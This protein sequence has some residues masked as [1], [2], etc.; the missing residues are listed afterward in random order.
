[1]TIIVVEEKKILV[2]EKNRREG[3]GVKWV[4]DRSDEAKKFNK[5]PLPVA[6]AR[7][8]KVYF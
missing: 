4:R 6:Y 7:V 3:I 2:V 1:M 5:D 8:F